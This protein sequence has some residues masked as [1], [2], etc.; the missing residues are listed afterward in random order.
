[1]KRYLF[2]IVL[3]APLLIA[4]AFYANHN[5]SS[6]SSAIEVGSALAGQNAVEYV[7]RVD[8]DGA[9]FVSYGYLTHISGLT[10]TLL[11]S[12]TFPS[13]NETNARF[14][15]YATATLTSHYV[16]S[17][18]AV[19]GSATLTTS[20]FVIDS[21]GTTVYYYNP[22]GGA[23]YSDPASFAIG[24]P[25]VT[26]TVRSQNILNVQAPNL[27]VGTNFGELAQTGISSFDLGGQTYQ[28]GRVGL[29]ERTFSTGEGTRTNAVIP[30]SLTILSGNA[31]VTGLP[32]Q[33]SFM[34]IIMRNSP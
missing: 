20:V 21:V 8:Q 9:N 23:H 13:V 28:I 16:I 12:G 19:V 5:P 2:L 3:A 30:Q 31:V 33:Q 10:D 26:A 14:T 7:G 29:M 1:M 18:V 27:G 34:P 22:L 24:Q 25:I 6:A 4:A 15:Y 17:N 11:F 32:G